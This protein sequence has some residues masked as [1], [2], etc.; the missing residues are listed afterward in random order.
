MHCKKS[1]FIGKHGLCCRCNRLIDRFPRCRCCGEK[2][3]IASDYC[4]KCLKNPPVWEKM[5]IVGKYSE[6]LSLL[7]HQFKFQ[8]QFFLA[9]TFS[10]LMLLAYLQAYREDKN[11]IKPEIILPVPLH[12]FRQWWRGYNQA[13][14][15]A[16]QLSYWLKIPSRNDL[17]F[18]HKHTP[19]QRGL[20]AKQRQKNLAKAFSLSPKFA[21]LGLQSVALVD[22]VITTGSTLNEIAKLLKKQGVKHI[23]VWGI[24]KA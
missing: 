8:N 14:L 4:G 1:L 13:D 9:R 11:L 16:K 18:R 3:E 5:V 17:I 15:L 19:T 12:H 24:A 6:P 23:Q 10:R 7:I 2:L 22:D 20:K 21:K